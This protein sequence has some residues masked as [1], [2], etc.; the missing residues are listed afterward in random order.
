[1]AIDSA[2]QDRNQNYSILVQQGSAGTSAN[3]GT[4]ETMRLGGDPATGALYVSPLG[5]TIS[6]TN[7]KSTASSTASISAATIDTQLLATNANR[8]GATVINDSTATLYLMLGTT[9]ST[10]SFTVKMYQDDYYEVPY[11]FTGAIKGIWN[12]ASGAARV[13]ELT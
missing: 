11:S 13:T 12:V 8:L 3:A 1:M 2:I 7:I 5:G 10:A 4:A 9:S 6:S